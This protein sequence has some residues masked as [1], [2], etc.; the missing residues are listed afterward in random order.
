M[1]R[2]KFKALVHYVIAKSDSSRLGA[3]RLNKILWYVDTFAYRGEGASVTGGA[4]VK[5]QHGPVPKHILAMLGELEHEN[6]IVIRDRDRF[7]HSMKDFVALT[8]PDISSLSAKEIALVDEIRSE[9]CYGHT[10][11]S[12][13]ELSHDQVW[14]A[15]N[16]GEEIPLW[17]TLASSP[18]RMT[19]TVI[20]WADTAISRYE[21]QAT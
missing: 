2:S 20:D 16:I 19:P 21:A 8:E 15:A 18:G 5:R 12:I 13:S 3:V 1:N 4:Y 10:A 11:E 7:G 9:I 14:E 17:A 6:A